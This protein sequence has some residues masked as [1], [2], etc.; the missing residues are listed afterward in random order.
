MIDVSEIRRIAHQLDRLRRYEIGQEI[1]IDNDTI[2]AVSEQ[3]A[4]DDGPPDE[5]DQTAGNVERLEIDWDDR[6]SAEC[7]RPDGT[8]AWGP[9][10]GSVGDVIDY[11]LDHQTI[12]T[13][14]RYSNNDAMSPIDRVASL[15]VA[16]FHQRGGWSFEGGIDGGDMALRYDRSFQ[17]T[18]PPAR[19]GILANCRIYPLSIVIGPDC[20]ATIE[21]CGVESPACSKHQLKELPTEFV[22]SDIHMFNA[23]LAKYETDARLARLPEILECVHI[24]ACALAEDAEING[25]S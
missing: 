14:V 3:R 13:V 17:V 19:Q 2:V 25:R 7:K 18:V 9:V 5:P 4:S 15:I 8:F 21:T 22:S 24:G 11:V 16:F 10:Q 1:T 20:M 12:A 6:A 23:M